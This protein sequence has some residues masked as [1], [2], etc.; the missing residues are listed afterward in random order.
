MILMM[1]PKE[2]YHIRQ[3][4]KHKLI[5]DAKIIQEETMSRQ[6][7]GSFYNT[8]GDGIQIDDKTKK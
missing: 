6:P 2:F 7:V 1:Q 5:K 3:R 8:H 4:E